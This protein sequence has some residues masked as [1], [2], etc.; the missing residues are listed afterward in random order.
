MALGKN[1]KKEIPGL[2]LGE[3]T[4]TKES[5]Q[6]M[7]GD[8][9]EEKGKVGT[10]I[11]KYPK[12]TVQKS[13]TEESPVPKKKHQ[14]IKDGKGNKRNSSCSSALKH[15]KQTSVASITSFHKPPN[16]KL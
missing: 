1:I 3:T 11:G 10:Y 6:E 2:N 7:K 5:K 15:N 12:R 8:I 4:K 16:D 14:T 13:Y 9:L